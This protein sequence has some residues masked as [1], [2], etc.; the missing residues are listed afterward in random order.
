MKHNPNDIDADGERVEQSEG[1]TER[2]WDHEGC[3]RDGCAGVL[4]QQDRFNVA[5]LSCER[6]W[7]HVKTKTTHY[8][9]TADFETVVEKPIGMTDG[10]EHDERVD[11]SESGTERNPWSE[12]VQARDNLSTAENYLGDAI[13][14]LTI[15][16]SPVT[17]DQAD[18]RQQE[19]ARHIS[20]A[21]R[22]IERAKRR[23]GIG[24]GQADE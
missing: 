17:H 18:E 13:G 15:G 9:Q 5:C 1:G 14:G 6:V 4:Q 22:E 10:G 8:L 16:E 12:I 21:E 2:V 23:L 20:N 24:G 19:I 11:Q 3:P 7:I